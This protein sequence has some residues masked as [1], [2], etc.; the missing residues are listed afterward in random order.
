[1]P[2]LLS[3]GTSAPERLTDAVSVPLAVHR[4]APRPQASRPLAPG[5]A[6]LL[7]TD[8]LVERRDEAIDEQ[9]DRVAQ[10]LWQTVDQPVESAAD[11][12]LGGLAPET[13]YD[14]DVAVV[15]Y[16]HADS[17]AFTAEYEAT[18]QQL[19]N[20][21][22]GLGEWLRA[23]ELPEQLIAD[24]ILVVNEA[25]TNSV[26]HAYRDASPGPM[27]VSADIDGDRLQVRVTD[28]GSWKSPPA[29][30]GTRGKGLLLIREVGDD[31]V[32]DGTP[33]G[34]AVAATFNMP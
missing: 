6:L 7:Y 22:H 31:V 4:E 14:D 5:A 23:N 16:R 17:P 15:L 25:C 29:D 18:A 20:V 27:R 34:T 9:I 32:L 2:P 30:P 10:V 26:E 3:D 28:F 8:G 13:G 1:V 19:S 33:D 11:A 12:I 24:V 21:R